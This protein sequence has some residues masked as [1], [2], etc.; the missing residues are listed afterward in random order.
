M[1]TYYPYAALSWSTC[2]LPLNLICGFA[3][4]S[5]TQLK[6]VFWLPAFFGGIGASF[7]TL[8]NQQVA[9]GFKLRP[10]AILNQNSIFEMGS[11]NGWKI[12]VIRGFR[13]RFEVL[14]PLPVELKLAG[15]VCRLFPGACWLRVCWKMRNGQ[16]DHFLPHVVSNRGFVNYEMM[17]FNCGCRFIFYDRMNSPLIKFLIPDHVL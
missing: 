1:L 3:T 2:A 11:G 7:Q 10:A 15:S 6:N 4:T 8:D 16:P 14:K 12:S 9:C 17:H 13:K 5:W